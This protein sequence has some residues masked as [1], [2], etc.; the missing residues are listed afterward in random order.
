MS[1]TGGA[2]KLEAS[3]MI[4]MRFKRTT[5]ADSAAE[6]KKPPRRPEERTKKPRRVEWPC[7]GKK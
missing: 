3:F 4:L 6:G 5:H 7:G 1:T 2:T